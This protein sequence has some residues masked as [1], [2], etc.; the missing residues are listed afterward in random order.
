M[1]LPTRPAGV[2]VIRLWTEG[3]A[4]DDLRARLRATSDV[5]ADTGQ[6]LAV[7]GRDALLGA[8]AAWVDGYLEHARH[9]SADPS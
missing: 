8:V 4:P 7:G 3:S 9:G 2:L 5:T 1:D 6:E